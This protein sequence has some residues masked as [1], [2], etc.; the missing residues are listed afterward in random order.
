MTIA[1]DLQM[2]FRKAMLICWHG[3]QPSSGSVTMDIKTGK[4]YPAGALS[5]F[6]PCPFSVRGIACGSM[7]G[8]L[9]GLKFKS[10]E[11]QRNVFSMTGAAAKKRGARKNWQRTQTP[12]FQGEPIKRESPEYQTLLDE[13]FAALFKGNQKAKKALLD[14]GDNPLSHKTGRRN[15]KETVLTQT[16]LCGRL[17]RIRGDLRHEGGGR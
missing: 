3:G 4:P 1:P 12:W 5:N 15:P 11:M 9:Q 7:E 14:S 8:F 6:C 2:S 13:A 10:A 17:M 16:E